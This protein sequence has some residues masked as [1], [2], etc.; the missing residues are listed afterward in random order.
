MFAGCVLVMLSINSVDC[1]T[2]MDKVDIIDFSDLV[3]QD[4]FNGS[5]LAKT[6]F[7]ELA[8]RFPGLLPP[9]VEFF[10]TCLEFN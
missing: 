10:S 6:K 9:E 4:A 8:P 7:K 5:Y 3:I 1:N 2:M